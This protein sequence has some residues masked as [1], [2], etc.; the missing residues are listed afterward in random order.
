MAFLGWLAFAAFFAGLLVAA[1]LTCLTAAFLTL[2]AATFLT[3]GTL[4]TLA[5]FAGDLALAGVAA[6]LASA[7]TSGAGAGAAAAGAALDFLGV[8]FL[9]IA[10]LTKKKMIDSY[11]KEIIFFFTFWGGSFGSFVGFCCGFR[12]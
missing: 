3:F 4:A 10:F 12:F 2:G 1:F 7:L 5:T 9:V 11:W 8:T 6:T